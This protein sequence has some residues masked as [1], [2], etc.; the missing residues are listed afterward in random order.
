MRVNLLFMSPIILKYLPLYAS[1]LPVS[2]Q[3]DKR[4]L[5]PSLNPF[6]LRPISSSICAENK[7][8]IN[9]IFLLKPAASIFFLSFFPAGSSLFRL[10][11][12]GIL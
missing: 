8:H 12:L 5:A 6:L 10:V 7:H 2:L 4:L 3:C 11:P 1:Q 9:L